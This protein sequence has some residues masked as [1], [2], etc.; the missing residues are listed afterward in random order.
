MKKIIDRN[1]ENFEQLLDKVIQHLKNNGVKIDNVDKF[2]EGVG[3]LILHED[4]TLE[5]VAARD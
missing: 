4:K 2:K 5:I 3:Q 1:N